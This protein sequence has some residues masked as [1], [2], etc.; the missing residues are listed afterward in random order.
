MR[1]LQGFHSNFNQNMIS[2]MAEKPPQIGILSSPVQTHQVVVDYGFVSSQGMFAA[3]SS[4][5]CV[6]IKPAWDLRD[7]HHVAQQQTNSFQG[8]GV[9]NQQQLN[10]RPESVM[11]MGRLEQALQHGDKRNIWGQE[12]TYVH[13]DQEYGGAWGSPGSEPQLRPRKNSL[14]YSPQ[15][16]RKLQGSDEQHQLRRETGERTINR[17][18]ER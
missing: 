3:T 15:R 8:P 7:F 2:V 14:Q 10:Q 6:H 1:T 12:S 13:Q 11:L 5:A 18:T 4:P 9:L 17:G 16:S